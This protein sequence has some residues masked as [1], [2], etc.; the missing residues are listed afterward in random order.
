MGCGKHLW[1]LDSQ[2][3]LPLAAVSGANSISRGCRRPDVLSPANLTYSWQVWEILPTCNAANSWHRR[4]DNKFKRNGERKVGGEFKY[5]G[6][7]DTLCIY[8]YLKYVSQLNARGICALLQCSC[9]AA[10]LFRTALSEHLSLS[11]LHTKSS[12]VLS[13]R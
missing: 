13:T 10:S 5:L 2:P 7:G 11:S 1:L 8:I 4:E 12:L 3:A 9:G 6:P